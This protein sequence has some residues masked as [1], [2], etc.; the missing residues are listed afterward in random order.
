M[1]K[2]IL[3]LLFAL[4]ATIGAFAQQSPPP[5]GEKKYPSPDEIMSQKIAFFTQELDLTPEE[6]QAFW[7]VYNA[8]W[9]KAEAAR[10]EIRHT[11]R[12]VNAALK[13]EPAASDAQINALMEK[14]FKALQTEAQI[15]ADTYAE[16]SKVIPLAKAAKACTLEEKFRIM[17]IRQLRR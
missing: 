7:P 11:L 5:A 8:G 6:A 12:E 17:M 14:Y 15:K 3:T 10:K 9:K 13:Q 4:I 2:T 16:V 1:K